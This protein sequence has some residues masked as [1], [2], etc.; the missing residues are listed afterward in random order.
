MTAH[1]PQG[2]IRSETTR[3]S[4]CAFAGVADRLYLRIRGPE[5]ARL[6]VEIES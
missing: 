6:R 2:W 4:R 3:G 1:D 5:E